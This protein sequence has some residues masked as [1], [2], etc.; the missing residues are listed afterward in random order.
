MT[1]PREKF[2]GDFDR[3]EVE[4]DLSK[5]DICWSVDP[6]KCPPNRY[7]VVA[8]EVLGIEGLAFAE[9]IVPSLASLLA[10]L[11]AGFSDEEKRELSALLD[12]VRLNAERFDGNLD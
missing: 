6:E 12:R 3:N 2:V 7:I 10:H 8:V 5:F 9:R 4:I 11:T 1:D